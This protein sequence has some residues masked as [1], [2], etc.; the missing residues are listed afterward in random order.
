MRIL[1]PH[2]CSRGQRAVC[3]AKCYWKWI[4]FISVTAKGSS[5]CFKSRLLF[6]TGKINGSSIHR[7]L[8]VKWSIFYK[9]HWEFVGKDN[10]GVFCLNRSPCHFFEWRTQLLESMQHMCTLGSSL[11]KGGISM[12][13]NDWMGFLSR[14]WSWL[15]NQHWAAIAMLDLDHRPGFKPQSNHKACCM[16]AS[17][18]LSGPSINGACIP[19][20]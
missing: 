11:F 3:S 9:V 19:L 12:I 16:T 10:P 1:R 15:E 6:I 20:L 5:A 17:P 13:L 14:L 8:P 7:L 4:S 2:I 18:I